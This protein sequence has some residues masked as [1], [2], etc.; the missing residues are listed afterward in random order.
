MIL[1]IKPI[2]NVAAIAVYREWLALDGVEDRERNKLFGK[3]VWSIIVRTVRG[4]NG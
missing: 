2:A 3:M 1:N 4:F